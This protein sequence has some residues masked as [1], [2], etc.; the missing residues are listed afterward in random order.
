MNQ[1]AGSQSPPDE[2]VHIFENAAGHYE[3]VR[4]EGNG[5]RYNFTNREGKIRESVMPLTTW[6]RVSQ[7]LR[8]K[9]GT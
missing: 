5:A 6:R 9:P 7:A 3:L 8:P 2:N 1:N 4:V